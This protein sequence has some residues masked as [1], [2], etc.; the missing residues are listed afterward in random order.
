MDLD[1]L[2]TRAAPAVVPRSA[3]LDAELRALVRAAEP[4]PAPRR[5]RLVVAGAVT[6]ALL[7]GGVAAATGAVPLPGG[8]LHT[9]SGSDC[10]IEL[11]AE[12][13]SVLD[14]KT[15]PAEETGPAVAAAQKWL[16]DVDLDAVDQDQAVR[17]WQVAEAAAR[18]SQPDPDERQPKLHGDDLQTQALGY[19]VGQRLTAY[20]RAQGLDPLAVDLTMGSRCD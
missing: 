19:A 12:P 20:L 1:D 14:G 16:A 3:E 18:A 4:R 8:W 6:A 17:D 7:G 5:R 10:R 9:P 15:Y 2:L 13:T 11:Y